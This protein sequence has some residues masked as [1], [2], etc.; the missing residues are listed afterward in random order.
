[1]DAGRLKDPDK[2]GIRVGK[3]INKRK[4]AKHFILDIGPGRPA[5]RQRAHPTIKINRV[6]PR[7]SP[8]ARFDRPGLIS[9]V[10]I[11]NMLLRE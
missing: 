3:V 9:Y 5:W 10:Q 8:P 1:V 6:R 11:S 7:V 4:V 2:I